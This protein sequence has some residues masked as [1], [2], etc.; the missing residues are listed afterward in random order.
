MRARIKDRKEVAKG[1]IEVTFDLLG[2]QIN[3]QPGQIF[4]I[5]LINPPFFDEKGA[6]R[7]FSLVNSPN[8]GNII[9]MATRVRDSAFKKSLSQ[10]PLGSEVEIDD[11]ARGDFILPVKTTRPLVMIAGGI[12]ITPYM[13]MFKFINEEKLPFK[14]IL[15]YSNR[16][17]SSAAYFN[18]LQQLQ[19]ENPNIKV[20]FSMTE[21]QAW[22]SEKR[23]IDA[24]LT[25]EYARKMEDPIYYLSGPPAMVEAVKNSL[26]KAGIKNSNIKSE[27]F[28]GY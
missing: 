4:S 16:D 24:D 26:T 9:T 27:S 7:H 15:I 5:T 23:R 18:K 12:G 19:K 28:S 6:R 2:K 25:Q 3:F 14:I 17:K 1:T 21:D 11:T 13:S 10:M 8:E 20:V 22:K